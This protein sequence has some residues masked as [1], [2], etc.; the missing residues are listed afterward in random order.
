M[1]GRFTLFEADKVLS[2]E[3]GVSGIPALSPRYN[4]APSQNV[5]AVR[6]TLTGRGREIA[7][8]RGV[9]AR[10]KVVAAICHGGWMLVSADVLRGRKA[11]CFF[12]I[13]DDLVNAGA[14]Y[15]DREVVRDGNRVTSRKPETIF[16]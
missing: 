9:F 8:V 15:E 7:L 14:R 13:K 10:G 1:C 12:A 4:I 2:R 6:T 3:F 11:T 16:G 5:A